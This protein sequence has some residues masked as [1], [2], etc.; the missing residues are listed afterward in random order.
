MPCREINGK[1]ARK[2]RK[3]YMVE[4]ERE[5]GRVAYNSYGQH[6]DTNDMRDDILISVIDFKSITR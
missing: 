4:R 3:T 1:R 2:K 6:I 5:E